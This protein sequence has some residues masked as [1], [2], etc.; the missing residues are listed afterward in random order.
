MSI[1]SAPSAL[2][3][4]TRLSNGAFQFSFTNQPGA[5]FTVLTST[6]LALPLSNWTSLGAP[7]ESP[8]GQYQYTDP[9]AT[10]NGQRFYRV[11]SP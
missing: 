8:A 10:N 7:I 6:N 9:A 1:A 2:E 11:K 5:S 3:N 4:P